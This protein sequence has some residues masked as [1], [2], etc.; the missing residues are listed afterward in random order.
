MT[1]TFLETFEASMMLNKVDES[2]WLTYLI[3][4][5][6]EKAADACQR[7]NYDEADYAYVRERLQDYFNVTEKGQ[8]RKVQNLRLRPKISHENYIAK[9]TKLVRGWLKPDEAV[10]RLLDKILREALIDG[11]T[12]EM[13]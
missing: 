13:M 8:Q 12:T 1:W 9:S 4:L 2:L 11:L 5:L 6:R 10:K 7:I 3:G